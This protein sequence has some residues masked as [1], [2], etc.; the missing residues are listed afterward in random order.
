MKKQIIIDS[1][2]FLSLPDNFSLIF[3]M[4]RS[5]LDFIDEVRKLPR[6]KFL[7]A[8]LVGEQIDPTQPIYV[9]RVAG[10]VPTLDRPLTFAHGSDEV[11]TIFATQTAVELTDPV[12]AHVYM[13]AEPKASH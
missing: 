2:G 13:H 11:T 6:G 5:T 1:N 12:T 9:I 4:E 3:V 7:M 10:Y 8:T